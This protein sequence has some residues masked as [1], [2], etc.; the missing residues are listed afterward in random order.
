MAVSGAGGLQDYDFSI[1]STEIE[2]PQQWMI[3][4]KVHNRGT[5]DAAMVPIRVENDRGRK[6]LDAVPLVRG[7]GLGIAAFPIG[8]LWTRGG[9]LTFTVNPPDAEGAFPE[10]NRDDNIVTFTLP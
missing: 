10:T 1:S 4:V 7:N 8:Y 9:V 5:R 3:L 2:I 6:I